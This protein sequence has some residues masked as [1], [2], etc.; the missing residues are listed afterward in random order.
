[1]PK[2]LGLKTIDGGGIGRPLLNLG[3]ILGNGKSLKCGLKKTS[4][5][6]EFKP[7]TRQKPIKEKPKKYQLFLELR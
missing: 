3:R 1:M 6:T 7:N 4:K 2:N 5:T